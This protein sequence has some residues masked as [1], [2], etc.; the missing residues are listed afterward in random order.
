MMQLPELRE[1]RGVKADTLKALINRASAEKRD[2]TDDEQTAFDAVKVDIDKIE[3]NMRNAEVAADVERRM[4]GQPV[5]NAD[6]RFETEC[7]SFSLL[8]AIASQVP[9]LKVDAAREKEISAELERRGGRAAQGMMVPMS[10]FEKRV[11]TSDA[12]C[13][14]SWLEHH[15]HRFARRSVH[16]RPARCHAHATARRS[17]VVRPPRQRGYSP[18][19]S[20]GHRGVGCGKC[21][22]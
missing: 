14:W 11:V 9:D 4:E 20:L 15:Q 22:D 19:E 17:R 13:R 1:Q 12:S 3:R 7:R 5:A 18:A 10:V 6:R 8:K 16:R 21:G 2:L